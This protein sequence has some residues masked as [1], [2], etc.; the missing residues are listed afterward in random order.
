MVRKYLRALVVWLIA[1]LSP[2]ARRRLA[3][4]VFGLG[5]RLSG[6]AVAI[7]GLPVIAGGAPDDDEGGDDDSDGGDD[8][9]DS[10]GDD[11]DDSDA[12]DTGGDDEVAKLR[13]ELRRHRRT[14]KR[15]KAEKQRADELAAKLKK[16]EDAD[17]SEHEKAL[18]DAR[19]TARDEALSEAQKERR[20][21]RLESAIVRLS[22]GIELGSG[23]DAKTV[24]FDDDLV[25]MAVE[26]AIA[27]GDLDEDD[28]FDDQGRVDRDALAAEVTDLLGRKPS[29]IAGGSNGGNGGNGSNGNGRRGGNADLGRGRGAGKSLDDMTP[30]DHFK[31]IS[32]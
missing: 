3:R 23:D 8:E 24:Q 26:R 12:S 14:E 18:E 16:I 27:K 5:E 21:E 7:R 15:A 22:K 11:E 9:D 10:D 29:L 1:R 25:Q 6:A 32:K 28:L 4:L 31:A 13:E 30:E 17:K 2:V 19:K 20:S